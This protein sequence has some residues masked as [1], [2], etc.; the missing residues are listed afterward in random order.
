[1]GSD[2]EQLDVDSIS[3]IDND[4]SLRNSKLT[5]PISAN[6]TAESSKLSKTSGQTP[7][8]QLVILNTFP[9]TQKNAFA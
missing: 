4:A 8:N 6:E 9:C 7:S 1:M 3:S 5:E 2:G